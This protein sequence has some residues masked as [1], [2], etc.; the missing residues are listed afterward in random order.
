MRE[1]IWLASLNSDMHILWICL[2]FSVW[3]VY[4]CGQIQTF[5]FLFW[6]CPKL[7]KG[8]L[9]QT[10][11]PYGTKHILVY[12]C[13]YRLNL[14]LW[15]SPT[16]IWFPASELLASSE[17]SSYFGICM[18][19]KWRFASDSIASHQGLGKSQLLAITL[20]QAALLS[21]EGKRLTHMI[22]WVKISVFINPMASVKASF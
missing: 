9:A 16:G 3:I 11:K 5:L 14:S 6:L 19:K 13:Q 17:Y 1:Q 8:H 22:E 4:Q 12:I 2:S 7:A 21:S 10:W 18:L 15:P 20:S